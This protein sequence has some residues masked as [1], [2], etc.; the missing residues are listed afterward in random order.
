[1]LAALPP[2]RT[3]PGAVCGTTPGRNLGLAALLQSQS[4]PVHSS[5]SGGTPR[6]LHPTAS[7]P[8]LTGDADAS[9]VSLALV[10][11]DLQTGLANVEEKL[12]L[13]TRV[14]EL[15]KVRVLAHYPYLWYCPL[16]LVLPTTPGVPSNLYWVRV[17]ECVCV[18]AC[19]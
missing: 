4:P 19:V 8:C 16:P 14:V 13:R 11:S 17:H 10:P 3:R 5:A 7:S 18:R 6:R 15:E 12:Y 9:G 2:Y 1:M